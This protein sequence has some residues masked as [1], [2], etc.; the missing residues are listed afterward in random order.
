MP[1]KIW[2]IYSF[3]KEVL[4]LVKWVFYLADIKHIEFFFVDHR[5]AIEVVR[6]PLNYWNLIEAWIFAMNLAWN[7][8]WCFLCSQVYIEDM[9]EIICKKTLRVERIIETSYILLEVKSSLLFDSIVI[10]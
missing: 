2:K 7:E 4:Y 10:D 8:H 3:V 9:L 1:D 6:K 5:K